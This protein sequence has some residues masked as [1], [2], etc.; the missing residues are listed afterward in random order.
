MGNA[1]SL[2]DL[3]VAMMALSVGPAPLV[4][5]LD[6]IRGAHLGHGDLKRFATYGQVLAPDKVRVGL[7]SGSG[8][9]LGSRT[10]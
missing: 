8:L 7:G 9:R 6:C 5:L 1:Q 4:W 3:S 2:E 10:R